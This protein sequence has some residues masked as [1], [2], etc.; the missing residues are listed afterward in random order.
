MSAWWIPWLAVFVVLVWLAVRVT[1]ESFDRAHTTITAAHT[2]LADEDECELLWNLPAY[3]P[4]A[5]AEA[6][7]DRLR[8]ALRDHREEEGT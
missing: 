1:R 2:S 3:D 7:F 4:D 6:G 8:Q 5:D